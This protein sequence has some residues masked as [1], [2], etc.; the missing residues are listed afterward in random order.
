MVER[1]GVRVSVVQACQRPA[2]VTHQGIDYH[3]VAGDRGHSSIARGRSFPALIHALRPD[4][5]HVHGLAFPSE[6]IELAAMAPDTPILLQDHGSAVPRFW[7]RRTHRR[8]LS[9]TAGDSF[10]A[11]EQAKPFLQ[12]SLIGTPAP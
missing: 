3:F 8:G 10:C 6:V 1:I 7:R 2:R 9:I 5:L 11:L 12:A 4:V